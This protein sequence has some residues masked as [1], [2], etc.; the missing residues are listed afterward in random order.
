MSP[1]ALVLLPQRAQ[2][3][4]VFIICYSIATI[5]YYIVVIYK[6]CIKSKLTFLNLLMFGINLVLIDVWNS[7]VTKSSYEIKLCKMTSN[8]EFLTPK[9]L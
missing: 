7:R 8:F 2:H 1:L 5:A 6:C 4:R 9:F 3:L